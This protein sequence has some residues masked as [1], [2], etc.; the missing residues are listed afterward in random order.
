LRDRGRKEILAEGTAATAKVWL[1]DRFDVDSESRSDLYRNTCRLE[2]H[3]PSESPYEVYGLFS[4]VTNFRLWATPGI[5]LPVK[6]APSNRELVAIDWDTFEASGARETAE[7]A[8]VAKR[9][10]PA[11]ARD[12][13]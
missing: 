3:L 9:N 8:A 2:V 7:R 12:D 11:S 4:V 10:R 13:G 5:E 6:V 1:D